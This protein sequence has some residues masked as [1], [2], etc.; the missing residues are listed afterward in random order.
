MNHKD[1]YEF[2]KQNRISKIA[3]ENPDVT[4][5]FEYYLADG[6]NEQVMGFIVDGKTQALC[7]HIALD[8]RIGQNFF[9]GTA[10]E[11]HQVVGAKLNERSRKASN[12]WYW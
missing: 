1:V 10:A 2:G 8:G 12:S 4:I 3:L 7:K 5:D 9:I 11:G 6:F